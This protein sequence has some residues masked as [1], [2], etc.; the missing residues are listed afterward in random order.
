MEK[1]GSCAKLIRTNCQKSGKTR[2]SE[3]G[4]QR[5]EPGTSTVRVHCI[6]SSKPNLFKIHSRFIQATL[7]YSY[8]SQVSMGTWH[9][10][11]HFRTDLYAVFA[12]TGSRV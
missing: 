2:I 12:Q 4:Q 9:Y 5:L 1:S 8:G 10:M 3:A 6:L 11:D 7:T